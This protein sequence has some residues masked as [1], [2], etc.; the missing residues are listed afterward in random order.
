MQRPGGA[1]GHEVDLPRPR[2]AR[3]SNPSSRRQEW[4]GHRWTGRDRRRRRRRPCRPTSQPRRPAAGRADGARPRLPDVV[5]GAAGDHEGLARPGVGRGRRVHL[6]VR[7][8]PERA[9]SCVASA[10][11]SP[12]RRTARRKRINAVEGE[13]GKR[14]RSCGSCGRCATRGCGPGGSPSTAST[15]RDE[16]EPAR[17]PRPR[18][19]RAMADL[20]RVTGPRG[21]LR[22]AAG[23]RGRR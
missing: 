21:R 10:T 4:E 11:W 22:P 16:A 9:P 13:P 23:R 8:P 14:A 6:P 7:R 17:L 18:V 2:R 3:A 5:G 19:E 1:G 12:S 20:E 15:S